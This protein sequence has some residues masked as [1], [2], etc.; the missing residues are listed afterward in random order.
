[1]GGIWINFLSLKRF[2]KLHP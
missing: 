1:M 2:T